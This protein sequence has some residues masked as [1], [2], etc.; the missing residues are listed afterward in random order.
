RPVLRPAAPRRVQHGRHLFTS[1]PTTLMATPF[2]P[3]LRRAAWFLPRATVGPRS[4]RW[5]QVGCA[6]VE[7]RIPN[8]VQIEDVGAV[9]VRVPRPSSGAGPHPAFLW[10][11]GGGLVMGTA[12][13][14]DGLCRSFASRAE[15]V[16]ASVNYRMPPAHVYPT[17]L[18]DCYAALTWLAA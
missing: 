7:R 9:T 3:E 10:I 6:L 2:A 17:A 8:D 12:A 15:C 1:P 5:A 13:Q 16:V 14:D 11:H 18:E 4:L